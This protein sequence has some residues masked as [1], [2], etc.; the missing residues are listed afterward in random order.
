MTSNR[1]QSTLFR[2][3]ASLSLCGALGIAVLV[4]PA[5]A[6]QTRPER[7]IRHIMVINLENESYAT[8]FGPDSPATY[9]NGT[10]LKQGQLVQKYRDRVQPRR[11]TATASMRPHC[12][13]P[14]SANTST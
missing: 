5:H 13:P 1:T 9:L 12:R 10:L 6:S 11:P 8:T 3:A 14:S 4:A 7:G 2:K